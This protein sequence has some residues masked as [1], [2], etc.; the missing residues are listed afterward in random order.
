[1]HQSQPATNS[2]STQ[3]RSPEAARAYREALVA[4]YHKRRYDK[5]LH[6]LSKK[7]THDDA[8]QVQ[9]Q[10]LRR[11]EHMHVTESARKRLRGTGD[12]NEIF[13][14]V[15]D[16]DLEIHDDH[17]TAALTHASDAEFGS[18]ESGFWDNRGE[19]NFY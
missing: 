16:S 6:G 13:V 18:A 14:V 4:R 11:Q 5:S 3:R 10:P 1:M 8:R 19:Y 12:T 17:E 2:G 15:D 9:Q 7:R